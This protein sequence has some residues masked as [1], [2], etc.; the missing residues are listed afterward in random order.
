MAGRQPSKPGL[1]VSWANM[2]KFELSIIPGVVI[3]GDGKILL[4]QEAKP[5]AKGLW[6][7]PAGHLEP[8]EDIFEAAKREASE[9]TGVKIELDN[10][11]GAYYNVRENVTIIRIVFI[12]HIIS[13]KPRPKEGEILAVK[14]FTP[15]EILAMP[16]EKLRGIREVIED[17][18]KGNKYPIT[19]VKEYKRYHR[20]V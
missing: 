8:H 18:K 5:I 10:F 9:E 3:E 14:W 16:S 1:A 6:N 4:V 20:G 2:A 7:I 11:L 15:D 19:V 17:Y 13:G 12:G